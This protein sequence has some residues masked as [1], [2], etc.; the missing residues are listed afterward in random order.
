MFDEGSSIA[1]SEDEKGKVS[2][3]KKGVTESRKLTDV[4]KEIKMT[5]KQL[6]KR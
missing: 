2:D 1:A 3:F 5:K 6:K 4:I